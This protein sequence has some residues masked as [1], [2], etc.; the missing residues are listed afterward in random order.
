MWGPLS[1]PVRGCHPLQQNLVLHYKNLFQ[2]ALNAAWRFNYN[3][4]CNATNLEQLTWGVGPVYVL[5]R[6][7]HRC[8]CPQ[9]TQKCILLQGCFI[10]AAHGRQAKLLANQMQHG[11][12]STLEPTKLNRNFFLMNC[13]GHHGHRAYKIANR[14]KHASNA[15]AR[16]A[17]T[18]LVASHVECEHA[19]ALQISHTRYKCCLLS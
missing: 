19:T 4:K 3:T 2:Y 12:P 16:G 7:G 15:P 14:C 18:T 5:A 1:G 8:Q 11:H 10:W 6:C 9:S 13:A 17:A